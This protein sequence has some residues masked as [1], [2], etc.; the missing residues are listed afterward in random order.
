MVYNPA[1]TYLNLTDDRDHDCCDT[2]ESSLVHKSWNDSKQPTTNIQF[3]EA[4]CSCTQ[5]KNIRTQKRGKA[6]L[7]NTGWGPSIKYVS[8][9]FAIFDNPL[10]L[11]Q[12]VSIF[13]SIFDPSPLKSADVLHG[14]PLDEKQPSLCEQA[15]PQCFSLFCVFGHNQIK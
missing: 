8:T 3:F 5:S 1:Y 11:Y 10:F 14:E 6:S 7:S 9:F 2:S 13:S 4:A 15:H 12:S